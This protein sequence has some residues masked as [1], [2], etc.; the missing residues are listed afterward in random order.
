M[1]SLVMMRRPVR[2]MML[3]RLS[4]G[5]GRRRRRGG[6][7]FGKI[8]SGIKKAANYVKDNK[9]ISR[10]LDL[11]PGASKY[12]SAAS[13]IG[14][15]RKRRVRRRRGGSIGSWLRGAHGYIKSNKL[16]SRGLSLIPGASKYASAAQT[17]G[18]GRKRRRTTRRPRRR[19][20]T[21]RKRVVRRRGGSIGRATALGSM[22]GIY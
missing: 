14:L 9:L 17:L 20:G 21:G 15:G 8:W 4:Y 18:Y 2:R 19:V 7:F 6:S 10:G 1:P 12:S 22:Y 3:P 13:A 16:V 11:I 5:V